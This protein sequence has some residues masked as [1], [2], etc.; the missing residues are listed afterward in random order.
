MSQNELHFIDLMCDTES[1]QKDWRH[2]LP[3]FY[4]ENLHV[5]K[6]DGRSSSILPESVTVSQS[7]DLWVRDVGAGVLIL[8]AKR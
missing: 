5:L 6:E 8:S 2:R 7:K 1:K 4:K 3:S